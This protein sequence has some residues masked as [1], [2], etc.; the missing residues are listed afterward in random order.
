MWR[1]TPSQSVGVRQVYNEPMRLPWQ[2]PTHVPRGTIAPLPPSRTGA[3]RPRHPGA[4]ASLQCTF[5]LHPDDSGFEVKNPSA[6]GEISRSFPLAHHFLHASP[7]GCICSAIPCPAVACT[8]A[9][10]VLF[11][12][13]HSVSEFSTAG[14][15]AHTPPL[16]LS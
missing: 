5:S 2:Q 15:P 12:A 11:K 3:S 8:P 14:I 9:P 7:V 1:Q 13:F 4:R 10:F 16:L 6:Q